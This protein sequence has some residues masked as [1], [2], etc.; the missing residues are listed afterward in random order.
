MAGE[1]ITTTQLT[2]TYIYRANAAPIASVVN[3]AVSTVRVTACH[4]VKV[5]SISLESYTIIAAN[6]ES[7]LSSFD[8]FVYAEIR[9]NKG[10][11]LNQ[12]RTDTLRLVVGAVCLLYEPRWDV[13]L[14]YIYRRPGLSTG[15]WKSSV[16]VDF[17]HPRR[18]VSSFSLSVMLR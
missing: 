8:Y 15:V 18:H 9:R 3:C 12:Q 17:P 4:T 2:C 6:G 16:A 1:I 10:L 7:N 5:T 13:I 11:N 14:P